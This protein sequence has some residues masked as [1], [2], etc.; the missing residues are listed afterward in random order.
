MQIT[1]V[2]EMAPLTVSSHWTL[3]CHF[4]GSLKQLV[5]SPA[6]EQIMVSWIKHQMPDVVIGLRVGAIIYL[7]IKKCR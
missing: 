2:L 1:D 5:Y 7:K 3:T 4:S 6:L